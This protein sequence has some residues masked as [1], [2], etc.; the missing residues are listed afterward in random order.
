MILDTLKAQILQ[1]MKAKDEV[2]RD[3]L[4]L[5]SSEVQK[6]EANSGKAPTDEEVVVVLRKLVK[7]NE[8]T[9]AL[10]GEGPRADALRREIQ[11]LTALLPKTM[12][13]DEIAAALAPVKDAI[14]A[15]KSD[16]QATGVA[17][18][19]MKSVGGTFEGNDVAAAAKKL[20]S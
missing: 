9:L 14:L 13:V 20:R 12:S 7:S 6:V 16:G 15:A 8:E 11:V 10:S 2:A 3:V 4:R 18:K 5:A 17:M 1:A 19:H